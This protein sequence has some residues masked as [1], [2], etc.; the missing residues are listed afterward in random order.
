MFDNKPDLN[1]MFTP[2]RG[3]AMNTNILFNAGEDAFR[4]IERDMLIQKIRALEEQMNKTKAEQE[5]LRELKEK[6]KEKSRI[7]K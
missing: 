3:N 5:K 7:Q 2:R 4:K 6:L 1:E